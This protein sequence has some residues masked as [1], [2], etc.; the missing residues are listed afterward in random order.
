M[1]HDS[2]DTVSSASASYVL[3]SASQKIFGL[4]LG[5]TLSGL[6]NKP[7]EHTEKYSFQRNKFF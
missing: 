7:V 3:A 2:L 6:T 5:L 4:G 1:L